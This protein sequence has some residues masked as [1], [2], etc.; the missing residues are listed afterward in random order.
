MH[1]TEE[2]AA[3]LV[4]VA[5]DDDPDDL[6]L[7]KH[8]LKRFGGPVQVSAF[9]DPDE[10]LCEVQVRD[11]DV[12]LVDHHLGTRTGLDLLA[13]LNLAA[14][15]TPVILVT[16]CGDE[17]TAASAMRAGFSD[18][19]PK[20]AL[21]SKS[22]KRSI[23]NAIE[24]MHLRR[25]LGEYR[26]NLERSVKDL[27]ARNAEIQ[28][29]YHS[30]SHEIKTPL[31]AAREFVAIVLDGLQGPLDPRQRESLQTAKDACDQMAVL[32]NDLL[33]ACRLETGKLALHRA[34]TDIRA[35]VDRT[36]VH[37]A[38]AAKAKG[39]ALTRSSGEEVP[40]AFADEGRMLQVLQNLVGNALKFTEAGGAVHIDVGVAAGQQALEISVCDTG[41]G[42][43]RDQLVRI[44]DR[45]YQASEEDAL[46]GGLGLG[47]NLCRELVRLHGGEIS[48]VSKRGEG[49]TFTFLVPACR[50]V[51]A[52]I[53]N[54]TGAAS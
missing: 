13:E 44:F 50:A 2:L 8:H 43:E 32:L 18:Y 27:N 12:I 47:L 14:P 39:I 38:A 41:R 9:L 16:D 23:T 34:P 51:E 42:I 6:L 53:P 20:Q 17:E 40:S 4:I 28:S 29:F 25:S 49:S 52:G 19:L 46:K 24:K 26:S 48:V 33:D 15:N 3:P 1:T 22:L 10:A 36:V 11:V 54:H 30:L 7:L 31:T 37:F 21:S 5:I 35:L 45:L